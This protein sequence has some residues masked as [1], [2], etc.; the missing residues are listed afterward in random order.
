MVTQEE[1]RFHLLRAK[2]HTSKGK[3][4]DFTRILQTSVTAMGQQILHEFGTKNS[5]SIRSRLSQSLTN[6]DL[7][8]TA[9]SGIASGNQ[10][11][12]VITHPEEAPLNVVI[13]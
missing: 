3:L 4:T 8:T 1:L 12:K 13:K 6:T 9:V 5:H 10:T 2:T 11:I 7:K